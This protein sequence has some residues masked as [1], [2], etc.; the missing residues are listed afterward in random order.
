V[1]GRP[2]KKGETRP[3]KS[4]RKKGTPNKITQDGRTVLAALIDDKMPK[5]SKAWDRVLKK[6]PARA[7]EI[8]GKLGEYVMPKLARTE[9]S[10]VGGGAIPIANANANISDDDAMKAYQR[11]VKGDAP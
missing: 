7:L 10:G 5:A 3:A 4:G 6:D 2:F 9:H 8:L 11:L 1:R